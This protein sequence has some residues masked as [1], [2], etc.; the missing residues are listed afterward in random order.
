M[1]HHLEGS[2]FCIALDRVMEGSKVDVRAGCNNL[3]AELVV[4]LERGSESVQGGF[5]GMIN[6]RNLKAG[7]ACGNNRDSPRMD[8]DRMRH[9]G[10]HNSVV[11]CGHGEDDVSVDPRSFVG[12]HRTSVGVELCLRT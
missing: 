9:V 7:S 5:V 4:Q 2:D 12:M 11:S 10:G 8:G 1:S 3:F 6:G